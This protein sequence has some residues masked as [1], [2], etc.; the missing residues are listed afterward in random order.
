MPFV[1]K[2]WKASFF[3][4]VGDK[5]RLHVEREVVFIRTVSVVGSG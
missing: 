5:A 4:I 2:E 1:S 3:G